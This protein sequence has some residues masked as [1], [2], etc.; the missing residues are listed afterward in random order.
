MDIT[1]QNIAFYRRKKG[2]TQ[3]ELSEK[4][5]LSRSFISQIENGTNNPSKDSLYK[6]AK[7]LEIDVD[8][9]I[10]DGKNYIKDENTELVKILLDLTSDLK[11]EWEKTSFNSDEYSDFFYR[12][13]VQGLTYDL[14]Y[15]TKTSHNGEYI[16]DI[17]LRILSD[18][19]GGYSYTIS[20]MQDSNLYKYLV[21]LLDTI[22]GL[23]RDKS[24]LFKIINNLEDLKDKK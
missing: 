8:Q 6:I 19:D 22:Q 7:V 5:G 10:D 9:L 14:T 23:E 1:N 3:K 4:T 13:E 18:E 2:L 11:I 15:S 16:D 12:T 20:S 21:D 24:P 17:D